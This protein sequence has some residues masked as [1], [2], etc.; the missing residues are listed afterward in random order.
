MRDNELIEISA[1]RL[2]GRTIMERY[3]TFVKPSGLIPPE[4]VTLTG[5]TNADVAHAPSAREAVAGL[6][7]FVQGCP[8]VAHRRHLRP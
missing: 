6:A 8:V 4:I 3:N 1:A 5:I 2:S 7:D